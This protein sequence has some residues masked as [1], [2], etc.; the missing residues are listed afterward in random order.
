MWLRQLRV[1]F[2]LVSNW[3][4]T[5]CRCSFVEVLPLLVLGKDRKP[6]KPKL[7]EKATERERLRRKSSELES[8]LHRFPL[9]SPEGWFGDDYWPQKIWIFL[10]QFKVLSFGTLSTSRNA[11]GCNCDM[12]LIITMSTPFLCPR[13]GKFR[14]GDAFPQKQGSDSKPFQRFSEGSHQGC[15][16]PGWWT[17]A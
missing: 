12:R 3:A 17:P 15:H 5:A 9:N 11:I 4:A 2:G 16:W 1:P 8:L 14:I 7:L 13:K 10:Q 6:I